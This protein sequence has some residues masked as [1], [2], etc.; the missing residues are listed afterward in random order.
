MMFVSR[1]VKMQ[2]NLAEQFRSGLVIWIKPS[3][4]EL[5]E[6]AQFSTTGNILVYSEACFRNMW[7]LAFVIRFHSKVSRV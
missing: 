3:T 7:I 6:A 2:F 4:S 1:H 5:N